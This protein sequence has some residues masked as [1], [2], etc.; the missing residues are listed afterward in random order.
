MPPAKNKGK[1]KAPALSSGA[2]T[3][4]ARGRKAEH[5]PAERT[6]SI[7][8]S[9]ESLRRTSNRLLAVQKKEAPSTKRA[10]PAKNGSAAWDQLKQM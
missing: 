2:K 3:A 7:T 1:G 6:K 9:R 10:N 5:D 8:E 4:A